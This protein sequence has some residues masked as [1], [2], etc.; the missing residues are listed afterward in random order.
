VTDLVGG[1][2]LDAVKTSEPKNNACW[3]LALACF[4]AAFP[5]TTHTPAPFRSPAQHPK[6]GKH[7][8]AKAKQK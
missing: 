4:N 2:S 6:Q 7:E 8:K 1:S 5:C 3:C